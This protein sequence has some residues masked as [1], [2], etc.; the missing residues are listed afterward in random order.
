MIEYF[1]DMDADLDFYISQ[2]RKMFF[3]IVIVY[4]LNFLCLGY[5][6]YK[7]KQIKE[8]VFYAASESG[9]LRP[10]EPYT[11]EDIRKIM[12]HQRK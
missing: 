10:L 11:S 8:P 5:V 7:F 3:R 12:A 2:F 4:C 1:D 6:F 9:L